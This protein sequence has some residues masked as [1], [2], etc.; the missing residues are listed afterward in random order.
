MVHLEL[1]YN[2]HEDWNTA[3]SG[4]LLE[5]SDAAVCV[6]VSVRACACV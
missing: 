4:P 5:K 3:K 2:Y 6:H 1:N